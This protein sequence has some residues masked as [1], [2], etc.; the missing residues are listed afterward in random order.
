MTGINSSDKI[1]IGIVGLGLM[2]SS[3]VVSLLSSGHPVVAIAAIDGEAKAGRQRIIDQLFELGRFGSSE[4]TAEE[5]LSL[6]TISEDYAALRD[7]AMV[8]ECVVEHLGIKEEVFKK[9]VANVSN[10][11]ILATNTSAIPISILQ[12]TIPQP[13]R[14]IGIHWAEPAFATRFMEIVCGRDTSQS[15]ARSVFKLAQQWGKEPTILKKDIRGFITNRLM[16]A[17]YREILSLVDKDIISFDDADKAFRYDAGSW[18]MLMGIF[19]RMDYTGLADHANAY[20]TIFPLLSNT[21]SLPSTMKQLLDNGAKGVQNGKGFY[22][23]SKAEAEQWKQAFALFNVDIFHLASQYPA[24]NNT[25]DNN[26]DGN[27]GKVAACTDPRK[28]E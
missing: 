21:E 14:F 22:N 3:I 5:S 12:Q 23:Y 4:Q 26:H 17:V 28:I 19:R 8:I 1:S 16:Y 11:T 25:S 13:Q 9:I 15:T 24:E 18:M 6:L 27:N 2:G 10:D 7:C 20:N